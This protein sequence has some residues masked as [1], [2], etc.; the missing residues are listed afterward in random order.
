MQKLAVSTGLDATA[1]L[2]VPPHSI[3]AEQA[4]LGGLMLDNSAWDKVADLVGEDDFYRRDHRLIFHAIRLLA[5]KSD[6]CDVVTLAEWLDKKA[7]LDDAGGIAYLGSLAGNTPSAANIKSYASIVRERSVLRQLIRVT[8]EIADTAFNPDGRTVFQ[9][10]DEAE[11]KVYQI[12]DQ[13]ARSRV[14]F[15]GMKDL[16]VKAV[17]KIDQLFSM[18]SPITG[19]AT[20]YADFDEMTA[21]LQKSDLVIVAGRP[22]MGKCLAHDAELVLDDGSMVT[23]EEVFRHHRGQPVGTLT[24][25]FR[26]AR[27]TPSDYVDDGLKPVFEVT[28][29]LGRRVETTFV[30]PFLTPRGWRHLHELAPGDSIAVPRQLPVF[31]QERLRECEVRLLA[32]LIGD[33]TLVG[34][35]VQFTNTN[36][37]IA[38]DFAAAV[39]AFGGLRL[40]STER[41]A[42]YASSWRVTK[43]A[44][45]VAGQRA[46]FAARLDGALAASGVAAR[47]VAAAVGVAP[48]TVTYWRQGRA[49]PAEAAFERLCAVLQVQPEELAPDGLAAAR[50]N[51]MNPLADWL[52]AQGLLGHGAAGKHVPS[53]VFRLAREQLALFLNRLFA[54]DGWATVLKSGQA[55]LGYATV[56]ERLARQVQHLL[57]RFGVLASLRLRWVKYRATRRPTWQLDITHADSILSF[58]REI[59]MFGKEEALTAAAGAVAQRRRQSNTD[60][61]P[62]EV[63]E[64]IEQ[65]K[66]GMCWAELARRAGLP[67]S[68]LHAHRRAL[69]RSRLARLALALGHRE[70]LALAG[71]DVYWDRIVSIVPSGRRQVYDLTVP[72]THN[73]IANDICVHNTSF[74]MNLVE[75][76]AIKEQKAVAVFSME[77]PGEQLAMR[78]MSSLGHIDQKKVRTGKLDEDDWPRLTSAVS[79]LA[80][81]PIF[82]DDTPA[83]SPTEV[84]AR[85]RRLAREQEH[86]LGLIVID[87][88]QLMQVPGSNEN[89]TAEISEISRSLKALAKEL[90]VPVIALSQLNRSLEQRPNKRPV[91]SD[92]RESGAIEQDADIIVFI[93]RD[94]VYNPDSPDKGTA[95]IIIGKQRNGPIGTVRLTFLG[96]YTR[97]ENCAH[98]GY[99]EY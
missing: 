27:A 70:L 91:M 25:E 2:K 55:Q 56:N 79:L 7:Q 84:R 50:K 39:E 48:A 3:E 69:S 37:R 12:A 18:D 72:H 36:P 40:S 68:N 5:E 63:W 35:T 74:A 29:R 15:T 17:D 66:G 21:G 34:N 16:L 53:Q 44:T 6:P 95:E 98:G 14:G 19:I 75:H 8:N 60:L 11:K 47:A 41:R 85:A 42:G 92:L 20:G 65:A 32:Y 81:A 61:V 54:T 22:S 83:L 96:Q 10:L 33:G 45:A 59:G 94:E 28:T 23:I 78:M 52:R 1:A 86:G 9:L 62:V 38:A 64:L 4:V 87:Y 57:L 89:R 99:E 93:Y 80:E 90:S 31:G 26:L 58:A 24:G 49:V 71:S 76:V 67:A 82:I 30:H 97:F 77:M 88:L 43:D 46:A 13:G 73:F 51:A